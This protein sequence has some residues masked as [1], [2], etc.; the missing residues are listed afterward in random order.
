MTA[1][2]SVVADVERQTSTHTGWPTLYFKPEASVCHNRDGSG[3]K[4][5][6]SYSMF[7]RSGKKSFSKNHGTLPLSR[8]GDS[9]NLRQIS[10][11]A[12]V[13]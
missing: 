3:Q 8:T 1:S 2:Q 9:G 12:L 11:N 6:H 13:Q 4:K 7:G 10:P 5:I